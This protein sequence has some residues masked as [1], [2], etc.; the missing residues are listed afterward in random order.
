MPEANN[1]ELVISYLEPKVFK[2]PCY[3]SCI[4]K[5]LSREPLTAHSFDCH[6]S[7]RC[8]LKKHITFV[9]KISF[10][11]TITFK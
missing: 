4:K 5:T 3:T 2:G 6:W 8:Q 11:Q 9:I 10:P 1:N 7:S